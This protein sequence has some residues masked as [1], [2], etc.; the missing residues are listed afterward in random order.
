LTYEEMQIEHE[1][2]NIQEMDLSGVDGLKG[3]Y[4]DENIAINQGLPT[5]AE[6][7]CILAEELGHHY[8]SAGNILD[9]SKSSNRKQ[10]HIARVWAYEY[11]I[12]LLGL[13]D[14]YKAGCRNRFEAAEHLNVTEEFLQKTVDF[15]RGRYGRYVQVG[16]Y[17]IFFEPCLG[18]VRK[19]DFESD[20]D[21]LYGNSG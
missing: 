14:C 21:F 3:L 19:I 17:V 9:Q 1:Y 5:I 18:I 20:Y 8:T 15:Y 16:D 13:I 4:L 6:K 11:R 10:E 12:G 2:L 7:S